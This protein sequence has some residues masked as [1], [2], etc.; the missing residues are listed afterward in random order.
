[1]ITD[2]RRNDDVSNSKM[3]RFITLEFLASAAISIFMMGGGYM[4]IAS[5]Q[6]VA[7]EER[8]EAKLETS[9][10]IEKI[11]TQQQFMK[12]TMA[13]I[14]KDTAVIRNDQEHMTKTL[15][16]NTHSIDKVLEILM[17]HDNYKNIP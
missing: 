9:K 3:S 16:K 10:K 5:E 8:L 12:D 2:N 11:E 14:E 7:K 13:N 17:K 4:A 1:M 15:E 6:K